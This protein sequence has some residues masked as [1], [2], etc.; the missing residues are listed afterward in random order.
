VIFL[1]K[2]ILFDLDGTLLPLSEDK[3]VQMYFGLL[4]NKFKSLGYDSLKMISAVWSGTE[5]M[6]HNDGQRTNET[7]FWDVFESKSGISRDA[8]EDDFTRFYEVEFDSVKITSKPTNLALDIIKALHIKGYHLILA[9]NPIFPRIATLQR[10][11][12]AGLDATMFSLIT[13]YENSSFSK[14]NLNYYKEICHKLSLNP[15]ECLM[16]GN[17]TREDMVVEDLGMRTFLLTECLNNRDN[18][19]VNMF[20][21]GDFNELISFLSNLQ[22]I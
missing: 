16:V 10:I 12:W 4:G 13:T 18:R 9:T 14:P 22:K 21:H 2:T 7:C 20:D 17:D 15:T 5:A 6:I 19:D 1:I 8:V 3:F 11:K